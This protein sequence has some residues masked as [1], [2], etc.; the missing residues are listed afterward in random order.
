MAMCLNSP[1]KE[2]KNQTR[3]NKL[4]KKI[5]LINLT[6]KKRPANLEIRMASAV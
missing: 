3:V 4:I 2:K 6:N 1:G 5:S